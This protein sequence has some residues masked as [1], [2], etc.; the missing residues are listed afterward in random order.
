MLKSTPVPAD[1]YYLYKSRTDDAALFRRDIRRYNSHFSFTS[2]GV[3]LDKELSNMKGGVYTFRA[4]GQ[5]YHWIDQLV[6]KEDEAKYLQLYFYDTEQE[7]D[8]RMHSA[9]YLEKNLVMR[10]MNILS[11]NPY[12][13]TFRSLGDLPTLENYRI[14]LNTSSELDQRVYNAPTASQVAA[15][16]VEGNDSHHSYEK[17]IVIHDKSEQPYSIKSYYPCYDP[18]SYALLFPNGEDGRHQGILRCG[19]ATGQD[20][21]NQLNRTIND[22]ASQGNYY[23][24][25]VMHLSISFI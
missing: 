22:E 23:V 13:Q 12:A 20:L 7:A 11:I 8:R 18:L 25:K 17:S 24:H 14:T 2:L 4:Q 15:I 10:L 5:I 9:P 3:R 21:I 16:W 6:P 19:E 1:L